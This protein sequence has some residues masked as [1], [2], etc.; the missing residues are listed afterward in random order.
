[1][2][3]SSEEMSAMSLTQTARGTEK[4]SATETVAFYLD[5]I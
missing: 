1:V 3:Y 5:P 4:A 2:P